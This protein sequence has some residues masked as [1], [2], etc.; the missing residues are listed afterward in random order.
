MNSTAQRRGAA[1]PAGSAQSREPRPARQTM[2]AIVKDHYGSQDVLQLRDIDKPVVGDEEVL[3]RVHAAGL[4]IGDWHFMTGLPYMLRI[5]GFGVLAPKI[6]V[7]GMDVAGTVEAAGQ[8]VTLFQTG[9]QIFGTCDG[10]FAEYACGGQD[11]FALKPKNVSF[12]H[13]ADVPT[14]GFAALQGLRDKGK[15]Q[16]GRKVLTVGGSEGVGTFAVQIAKFF[17]AEVTGVCSAKNVDMVRSVGADQVID[18]TQEGFTETEQRYDLILEMGGR[19]SLS[20]IRRA[21]RPRGHLVLVG[22]EGGGRWLGG[23]D[24]WIRA[25]RVSPFVGQTLGPLATMPRKADLEFLKNLIQAGKVTPVIDRTYAMGEVPEA[26]RFLENGKARGKV[27]SVVATCRQSQISTMRRDTYAAGARLA[28]SVA[29]TAPTPAPW[30]HSEPGCKHVHDCIEKH[31][32]GGDSQSV[33][34]S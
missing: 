4:H 29:I 17:G 21:L 26:F 5:A 7:R 1:L 32:F 30:P 8:N 12:E 13:A 10:S 25:L 27:V 23:T 18:Y 11:K 16:P 19:R 9:D 20:D 33:S 2:K 24:R 6:H 14:Y 3:I 22:A 31:T 28:N 15:I 34:P